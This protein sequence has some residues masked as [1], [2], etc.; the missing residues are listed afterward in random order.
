MLGFGLDRIGK[1]G[2][3]DRLLREFPAIRPIDADRLTRAAYQT[4]YG[5]YNHA[6]PNAHPL[7]DVMVHPMENTWEGGPWLTHIRRY[8]AHR[9]NELFRISLP[10]YFDMP[11]WMTEFLYELARTNTQEGSVRE[12]ELQRELQQLKQEMSRPV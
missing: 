6:N 8:M 4:E 3:I 11:F 5:I 12:R 2:E 1:P 9:Y 10:E 7:A